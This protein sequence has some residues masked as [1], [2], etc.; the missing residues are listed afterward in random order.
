V[1]PAN[2]SGD[3]AVASLRQ[4]RI[5]DNH[6]ESKNQPAPA[7]RFGPHGGTGELYKSTVKATFFNGASLKDPAKLLQLE[8]RRE[9]T[10]GD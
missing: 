1:E 2:R 5:Y 10:A 3:N 8:S 9:R 4:G 7:P 6:W